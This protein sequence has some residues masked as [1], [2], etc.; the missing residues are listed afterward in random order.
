MSSIQR[1]LWLQAAGLTDNS[2]I[3]EKKEQ[4]T[5]KE[6]DDY[7]KNLECEPGWYE[8]EDHD[9]SGEPMIHIKEEA[10]EETKG[11]VSSDTKGKLHELLVGYHLNGKKHMEK[12][13]NREGDSPKQAHDKLKSTIHPDEYKKIAN[14]AKG[15][16]DHIRHHIEQGGHKIHSVH[17]TSKNGD[18]H[19]STGIHSD[20]TQDSSDIVVNTH[21]NKKLVHHGVSLKVS[22]NAN[23][24]VPVSNLGQKS[25]HGAEEEMVKHKEKLLRKYPHLK[26]AKNAATRKA[27]LK[28]DPEMKAHVTSENKRTLEHIAKKYHEHLTSLPKHEL[29]HHIKHILHSHETPMQK[30]GH[31]HIR[32]TTYTSSKGHG[33]IAIVPSAHHAHIYNDPHRIEVHHSGGSVHFKHNGKTFG[34]VALKLSTGSDPMSSVK[35]S[36]QTAGD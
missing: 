19:A 5:Q 35:G 20:Q 8:G 16:A 25:F 34:R 6:I 21:H 2:I 12:H 30:Q 28:A 10:A 26:H 27:M 23:K 3:L 4:I 17:W 11:K 32:H 7:I 31:N 33:H 14:R 29:V 18:I 1:Q 15:A 24:H 13:T 22:D 36:G 9:E